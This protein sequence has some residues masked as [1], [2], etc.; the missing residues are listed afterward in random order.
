MAFAEYDVFL[1]GSSIK[2]FNGVLHFRKKI[3]N[4]TERKLSRTFFLISASSPSLHCFQI[5]LFAA[6]PEL[7]HPE[8]QV[9]WHG[10]KTYVRIFLKHEILQSTGEYGSTGIETDSDLRDYLERDPEYATRK[11]KIS[12]VTSDESDDGDEASDNDWD[13][14]ED[15]EDNKNGNN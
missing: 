14:N 10:K 5:Q 13:D 3:A 7:R 2:R 4:F 11:I 6:H 12:L 9:F 8:L 15:W 1:G